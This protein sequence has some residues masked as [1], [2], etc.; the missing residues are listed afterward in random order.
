MGCTQIPPFRAI[1]ARCTSFPASLLQASY[2]SSL[3][4][5]EW[6]CLPTVKPESLQ[7]FQRLLLGKSQSAPCCR[8]QW[9]KA[10]TVWGPAARHYGACVG[11]CNPGA[12]PSGRE[13]TEVPSLLLWGDTTCCMCS[14][15]IRALL[16]SGNN[17][18][19]F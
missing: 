9:G 6:P 2:F 16:V 10:C 13:R 18:F 15:T 7:L 12:G 1:R 3:V 8:G 5:W 17:V 14:C 11:H 4:D 19:S